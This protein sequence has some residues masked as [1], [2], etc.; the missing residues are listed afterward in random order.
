MLLSPNNR[1]AL[2]GEREKDILNT[3]ALSYIKTEGLCDVQCVREKEILRY[4][5]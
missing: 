3:L 1:R 5:I 2:Q 4:V